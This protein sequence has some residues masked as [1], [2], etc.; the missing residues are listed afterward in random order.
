MKHISARGAVL[1]LLM[2]GLGAAV[3]AETFGDFQYR[4]YGSGAAQIVEITGY[5]GSAAQV[6]IPDKI[7]GMPVTYIGDS[8][9]DGCTSLTSVTIPNS[10]PSIGF[11]VFRGC[12]GLTSVTIPSSVTEIGEGAFSGCTGLTSVTIPSSVAEIGYQAFSGCT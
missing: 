5:N 8:A 2:A 6:T 3:S 4:V 1:V 12:T 7:N 10:V 11:Y 9:F